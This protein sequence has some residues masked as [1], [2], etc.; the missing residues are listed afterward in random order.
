MRDDMKKQIVLDRKDGYG[1]L[2]RLLRESGARHILLVCGGSIRFL[3]L[4][5]YFEELPKRTGIRV[6]RFSGF[7]PNPT[8]DCVTEGVRLFRQENCDFVAAVGGGSAIDVGKCIKLWCRSDS[9]EN[10][11]KQQPVPNQIPLLAVPTTAGSGSEATRFAVIYYQG[12][13]QSIMNE[14]CVPSAV[15]FDPGALDSVPDYHRKASLLDALCHGIE[16]FWS[17]N[18]T[19]QSRMYSARA[20]RL[21][22]SAWEGYLRCGCGGADM[23]RAAH[24]AGKAINI[25]QTTAGHAMAYGLTTKYGIAHGHAAALCVAA[26]WPYMLEHMD[27]CVDVRGSTHLIAVLRDLSN[28]MGCATVTRAAERFQSL[29][30]GLALKKPEAVTA[31]LDLLTVLVA[32]ERLRNHPIYMDRSVIRNLY[33]RILHLS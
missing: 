24:L 13:K 27:D 15:F 6:S 18:A 5:R 17:V 12:R 19:R 7:S 22:L 4:N 21:I 10:Y 31:D 28:A 1:A 26:L 9:S 25:A 2:D 3:E 8:Y 16:A 11:L 20:I 14:S 30:N 29:L 32:P 23:L 33:C